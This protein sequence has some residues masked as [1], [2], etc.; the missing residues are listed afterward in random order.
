MELK[1]CVLIP[2]YRE[3]D[4][5]GKVVK[6]CLRQAPTVLVVDDGSGD[7]TVEAARAAGAE[8]IVHEKNRGKGVALNT[9]FD[10][11]LKNGFDAVIT[12]DGDGQHD[13]DEIPKFLNAADDPD[14]HIVL[15][16]RMDN[17]EDMPGIR[18]WSNRTTSKWV[19]RLSH[20]EIRD[21]QSGYRLIKSEV[22]RQVHV[23]S[24]RYDAE[25]EL[26]IKAGRAGFRVVEIPIA[27]IYHEDARSSINPVLDTIRFIK[28]IIRCLLKR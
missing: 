4:R 16:C 17:V 12:L 3:R 21:S 19:T 10:W 1:V 20:N 15:G 7:G 8:V 22:L 13:P 26:L 18:Q 9:G 14:V 6:D 2:C 11:T 5:I 25:P 24:R 28:L 27:T 23:R